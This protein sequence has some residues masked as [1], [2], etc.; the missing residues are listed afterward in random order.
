MP[1]LF[2]QLQP[3][4]RDNPR[5][6]I[7]QRDGFARI[8]EHFQ[9]SSAESEIGIVLPVG[10]GKSGLI[11]IAPF[12]C[13]SRR[14]LVVAPY[15][16]IA[17]QLYETFDPTSG[18]KFFYAKC[19]VLEGSVFP[20]PVE[21]RGTT[22]NRGDLDESDVVITNI[23]QLQGAD[24]RWLTNLP[25]DYFDLILFDE[26]HHAVANSWEILK[27]T[28]PHA[29]IINFSATP[30]RADG[31]LMPGRIRYSYP[32][33]DAIAEGYV[34]RLKALVLNPATLRYV[35]LE[36]EEE[37]E[38]SLDEVRRLGEEDASFRRS[39]V[40]SQ[41]TLTTIIDASIHELRRI[42]TETGDSRHKIIAS[43][44]NFDHCHQIV[45]GYR[46][47]RLRA[48]FI[49]S[50]LQAAANDQVL[51]R[52]ENHQLDVIV[53]VRKLGEGFD[54]SYLSVA[55][56]CSIFSELSPFVQFVGRIMRVID[57]E[58][59]D[60]PLNQGTVVFHAGANIARRWDDF[61]D[62]SEADQEFF[63]QLLPIEGLDFS[64]ATE[65]EIRPNTPNAAQVDVRRQSGV[66]VQEIPL[67]QDEEA[68][69]AIRTLQEG[70]YSVQDII[71]AY[72]HQP[73]PTTRVR[74]RQAA[75]TRLDARVRLLAGTILNQRNINPEGHELDRQHIGKSNFVTIK[76]RID[77]LI[78]ERVADI[79]RNE[80]TQADLDQAAGA[81]ETIRVQVEE[82]FFNA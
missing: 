77:Q 25:E 69:R 21:I 27:Q 55:A 36:G 54:H 2:S 81:L 31:Q 82:E 29:R 30:R 35:R 10:C 39:I 73:I 45:E 60:S 61:R 33:R 18:D 11:S 70:G 56:V 63:D 49:H 34:K 4:I 64:N 47:R 5:L 57:Q 14:V 8:E 48:D 13:G 20:E 50:R 6:R 62:F 16:K 66:T 58:D 24:N 12:A 23:D 1:D 72:E 43:A 80:Y 71:E 17:E 15:V 7:P 76:S 40:S 51:D 42:R 68:M 37:I 22:T 53:Q 74:R 9:D 32:V 52:L 26:G 75:R 65:I 28:F 44:L 46:A 78:R 67:L 59:K 79:P 38:V 3:Y 41:E 19:N